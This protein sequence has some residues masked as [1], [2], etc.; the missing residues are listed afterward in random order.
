MDRPIHQLINSADAFLRTHFDSRYELA[1]SIEWNEQTLPWTFQS[2][3]CFRQFK[4]WINVHADTNDGPDIPWGIS[5]A[6]K[7]KGT[8]ASIET[9][10]FL[11]VR[12]S[13]L[14]WSSESAVQRW[15]RV[16]KGVIDS[17]QLRWLP[18]YMMISRMW[19]FATSVT[20]CTGKFI[21][22]SVWRIY[23]VSW[24]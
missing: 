14:K 3:Q 13:L 7:A 4:L 11:S 15:S 16:N 21:Y 23:R 2:E 19:H 12:W 1:S 22:S 24:C 5:V 17:D 8:L 9:I 6:N 18:T 20:S 10:A